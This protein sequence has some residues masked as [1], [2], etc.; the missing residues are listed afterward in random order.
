VDVLNGSSRMDDFTRDIKPSNGILCNE[1]VGRRA[2]QGDVFN[3]IATIIT[4]T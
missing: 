3:V 2:H 1:E 4:L